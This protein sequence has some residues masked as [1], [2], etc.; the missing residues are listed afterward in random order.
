MIAF[1]CYGDMDRY[2]G[3]IDHGI[4]IFATGTVIEVD[5]AG[6]AVVSCVPPVAADFRDFNVLAFGDCAE[7]IR[8]LIGFGAD[9]QRVVLRIDIASADIE[10]GDII[11]ST[12]CNHGEVG[13]R[14]FCVLQDRLFCSF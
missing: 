6:N 7:F 10:L 13:I 2:G 11:H 3:F 9:G 12:V 1:P 8:L 4:W 14:D 5:P